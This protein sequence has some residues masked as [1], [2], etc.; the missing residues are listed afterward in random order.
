VAVVRTDHA[1][2]IGQTHLPKDFV[3]VAKIYDVRFMKER[4]GIFSKG[5]HEQIEIRITD[6]RRIRQSFTFDQ[7]PYLTPRTT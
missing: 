2:T 4:N 3:L 5:A 6:L 1:H 7:A